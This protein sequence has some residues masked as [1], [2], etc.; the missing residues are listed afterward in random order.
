MPSP[1]SASLS[2][3]PGGFRER[4]AAAAAAA[5]QTPSKRARHAYAPGDV[6][7]EDDNAYA[8]T[9]QPWNIDPY[10]PPLS[11]LFSPSRARISIGPTPQ[12]DGKVLGLF[13]GMSSASASRTPS[14]RKREAL[15]PLV[16]G[17]GNVE[18]TPS[19]RS[20]NGRKSIAGEGDN[21]GEGDVS[22]RE[23]TGMLKPDAST[24]RM[25]PSKS[26]ASG[27]DARSPASVVRSISKLHADE[28]PAFLRR[29]S[30][31]KQTLP[32][33]DG[34]EADEVLPWSP[35]AV[36]KVAVPAGRG[37]SALVRSLREMEAEKLDDDLDALREL[38]EDAE[39]GGRRTEM[40]QAP[41]RL[42]VEDGQAQ[43]MPL[44][45][46]RGQESEGDEDGK[47]TKPSRPWKK[48]GQKRTTR[49]VVM[50]PSVVK[51]QP[52]PKWEPDLASDDDPGPQEVTETQKEDTVSKVQSEDVVDNKGGDDGNDAD[53]PGQEKGQRKKAGESQVAGEKVKA[54]SKGR[55]K[56]VKKKK[57][58]ATAHANFRAL[59]IKNKNSKAKKGRKFGRR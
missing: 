12:K 5:T 36:R 19:K 16:D 55:T 3:E 21:A 42:L 34:D 25:T 58:S 22:G 43:E 14:R 45:P 46:D 54:K 27:K 20:L 41:P 38:E 30:Q 59:K 33:P 1:S 52:E 17:D 9:L 2:L 49:K 15:K 13:D 4:S 26:H 32:R 40:N 53:Y 29:P 44:G 48:K 39:P 8:R 31:Y 7:K 28:T 51:R 23:G 56:E 47:D 35:I 6:V 57:I 11:T 24:L 50:K 18:N 10:D 37:L